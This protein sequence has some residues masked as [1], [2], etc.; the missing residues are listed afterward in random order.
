MLTTAILAATLGLTYPETRKVDHT[1]DYNGVKVAD[2][3][4]WLEQPIETPEVKDWVDAQNKV[5]FGYLNAITGRDRLLKELQRRVNYERYSVPSQARGRLF[6]SKN[7]GLQNQGVLYWQESGSTSPKL[8]LDPNKLSK[9]GTVSV[10]ATDFGLNGNIML[11]GLSKGGSDWTEWRARDVKTGKDLPDVVI[12]SKFGVGFLDKLSRGFY[13]LRFNR[14]ADGTELTAAND[15]PTLCYHL[16]GTGQDADKEVYSIPDHPTWKFWPGMDASREMIFLPIYPEGSPYA[17]LYALDL[18]RAGTKPI[19]LF[20]NNDATYSPIARDGNRVYVYTTKN[21]PLGK[22]ISVQ[23]TPDE[24]G[25]GVNSVIPASKDTLDSVSFVGGRLICSYMH[26][27]YSQVRVFDTKGK[28]KSTLKLPGLG[29]V[30]GFGGEPVDNSTYYSYADFYTPLTI[31]KL[32]IA[33]GKSTVWKKPKTVVN[34]GK[35]VAKQ[36]FFKSKDGTKV[37]MFVIHKKDLKYTGKNPTILYGYGGFSSPQ[38]PWFSTSRSVWMDMGGVFCVANIRGGSEYGEDWWLSATKKNK[39]RS[40]D[41]FIAAGEWLIANKVCDNAHLAIQGGSNGG[42]LVGACMTQRP[43]LFGVAIPEVGVMDLLRFNKF[44]IGKSWESDFG[45]PENPEEF[46]YIRAIS[47]YHN[48]KPGTKYPAT[49]VT[50]ADRDDRVVPCHSFKFAARLQECNVGDRPVILR[51][52]TTSGHG[53]SNLT[54]TLE[55]VRDIYSFTLQN[56]GRSI[57]AKW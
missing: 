10:Q 21:A 37:P 54:K 2:P 6:F 50:T 49:L 52:E 43:E 3:Y 12:N 27:A 45:S 15:Q 44:T 13:Y 29:D 48:L 32:D 30:S 56:M 55:E 46:P 38:R 39:Q 11:Y 18:T 25:G 42:L 24:R 34:S 20:E 28:L 26:D 1:D 40:Y 53:A 57:P 8:L 14:S 5:T 35:Y 22:V 7:D 4:R 23:V 31:Y 41:D 36:V 16:F 9:D 51:V 47:P 19:V 17:K 33:S